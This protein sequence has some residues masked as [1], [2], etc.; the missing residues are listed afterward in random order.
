VGIKQDK[1]ESSVKS[2][3]RI[4]VVMALSSLCAIALCACSQEKETETEKIQE[5][6]T[7]V[8]EEKS[9]KIVCIVFMELGTLSGHTATVRSVAFSPDGTTLASGSKDKTIKL[10]DVATGTKLRTL[11]GHEK[12]VNSVA[13][14]PDGA[15]L[16]SGSDFPGSIKLWEVASGREL[17]TLRGHGSGSIINDIDYKLD[18]I[19]SVAFSPD[20]TTIASGSQDYTIKLWEV[21]SGQELHTF[22]GHTSEVNSVA[23]SPDGATL[24]SGSVDGTIK[25]WG[26]GEK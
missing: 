15:K 10:W 26:V 23:F 4:A 14:S 25:L 9:Q 2:L 8:V 24:A 22:R 17:R 3:F 18:G 20:G 7:G 11:S 19:N 6:K 13:F 21:A 5:K 16:A 12:I 1:D